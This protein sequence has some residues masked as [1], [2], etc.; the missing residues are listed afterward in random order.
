VGPQERAFFIPF[1]NATAA[2]R[3]RGLLLGFGQGYVRV[4]SE[5]PVLIGEL[6]IHG[7]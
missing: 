4:S 1:R 3:D 7:Y 2:R 5:G 6:A